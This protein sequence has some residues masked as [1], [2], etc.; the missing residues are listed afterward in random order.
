MF[1]VFCFF[2][3][4]GKTYLYNLLIRWCLAGCPDYN[5]VLDAELD[6]Q[7]ANKVNVLLLIIEIKILIF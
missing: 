1:Y 4:L 6:E 3:F 7:E 2:A 5:S